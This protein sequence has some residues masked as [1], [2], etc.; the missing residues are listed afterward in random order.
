MV[1]FRLFQCFCCHK[2]YSLGGHLTEST[3]L[4]RLLCGHFR[5]MAFNYTPEILFCIQFQLF[6][7]IQ[8][9]LLVRLLFLPT[10]IVNC[11][12]SK[13]LNYVIVSAKNFALCVGGQTVQCKSFIRFSLDQTMKNW[14]FFEPFE[15][16]SLHF[17]PVAF[18]SRRRITHIALVVLIFCNEKSLF[19]PLERW[20]FTRIVCEVS[21]KVRNY[22]IQCEPLK[23]HFFQQTAPNSASP[24]EKRSE[25]IE[26]FT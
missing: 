4:C 23:V 3:K 14:K 9:L 15:L 10:R 17:F 19:R 7:F 22:R 18:Q 2:R 6:F 1:A 5:W 13:C 25:R 12:T 20:A 11:V 8:I 24:Q 26:R 21:G 16:I